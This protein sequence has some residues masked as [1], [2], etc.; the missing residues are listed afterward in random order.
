MFRSFIA[1]PH[2]HHPPCRWGPC[3][4]APAGVWE[5]N[6]WWG[7]VG[8]RLGTW[9]WKGCRWE[10]QDCPTPTVRIQISCLTCW[11]I[12]SRSGGNTHCLVSRQ[13]S[14]TKTNHIRHSLKYFEFRSILCWKRV[15]L[16]L[17]FRT[18][19]RTKCKGKFRSY[20]KCK[21]CTNNLFCRCTHYWFLVHALKIASNMHTCTYSV[22]F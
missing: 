11:P 12:L 17:I 21:L 18:Y 15:H 10:R 16:P 19:F 6:R 7:K 9:L 22:V 20:K 13:D 8:N 2:L 4:Q 14:P 3:C 1:V 5:W